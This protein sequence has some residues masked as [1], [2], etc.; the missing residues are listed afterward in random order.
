MEVGEEGEGEGRPRWQ[1]AG[2]EA[3]AA[4]SQGTRRI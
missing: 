3:A 1:G 4:G 2:E